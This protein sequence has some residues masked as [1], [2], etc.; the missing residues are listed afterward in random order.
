MTSYQVT[1]SAQTLQ[2]LF[3]GDSQ[4]ALLL[5][6]VLNQVLEAQVSEH[7]HAERYERSEER[8]GYRNGYKPAS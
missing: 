1:V 3:S 6:G 8:A 4:L 2:R 5:E 7:L